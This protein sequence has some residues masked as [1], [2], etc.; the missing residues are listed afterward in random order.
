MTL[1]DRPIRLGLIGAGKH[2]RRYATHIC[3]DFQDSL[4]LVAL[5]RSDPAKAA[6]TAR[7]FGCRPYP[8]YRELIDAADVDALVV[9]VPPVAHLE[10]V[11][12]AARA[13]RPILLEKPAAVDLG[14]GRMLLDALAVHPV[15]VMVAQTL[16]YNAVVRALLA[17]CGEIGPVHSLALT[18]RFE[19]SRL[20]W[21]DD[22]SRSGGG[23]ILHTGVHS[24]DLLRL[25]TGMEANRVAC[26]LGSVR[27]RRTEDNFAATVSLGGGAAL[28]VVSCSRAAGGRTGY[29]EVAGERG[30]L[31]GDH[32]GHR[33]HKVVGTKTTPV[34][35]GDP[36]PT[37]REVLRDFTRAL[38]DGAPMPIPLEE[39]LRAVAVADACYAAARS[40]STVEVEEVV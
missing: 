32:V 21:I 7:E 40:G 8:G 13:G 24:F 33:L 26:H 38:C 16:R 31:V 17:Q 5:A 3:N 15:P 19:P 18:Q 28:A 29:I 22:P 6:E 39:G 2:G 20:D 11:S 34:P 27:T 36:V 4:R 9:V 37:V 12:A 23:M 14:A 25:L 1:G 10:I 35:L 30:T